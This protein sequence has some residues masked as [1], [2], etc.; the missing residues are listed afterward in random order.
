MRGSR[1]AGNPSALIPTLPAL[2][3]PNPPPQPDSRHLLQQLQGRIL[4][5]GQALRF[6]H[7]LGPDLPGLTV[8]D[9]QALLKEKGMFSQALG[10]Q[11]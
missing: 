5:T 9:R 3:C 1:A 10:R 11:C 2:P 4:V 7:S 8:Q 6:L